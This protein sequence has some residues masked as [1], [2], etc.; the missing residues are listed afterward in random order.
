[1]TERINFLE[2]SGQALTYKKMLIYAAAWVLV[3]VTVFVI[4]LG[5]K[6]TVNS[7]VDN[8]KQKLVQLNARKENTM[9]LIEA[10]NIPVVKTEVKKLSEIFDHFPVWSQVLYNLA[11]T[12][13]SQVWL[14]SLSSSYGSGG[15]SLRRLE[16]DGSGQSASTIANF[17]TSLNN[18]PL[19]QNFIL[20]KS[21]RA[22]VAKGSTGYSFLIIGEVEFKGKEWN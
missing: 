14:T 18:I 15:A 22:D 21:T 8:A 19:F 2:K 1:M 17:V 16:I 11:K 10:S 3:C 20:N 4:E 13:P 6:W 5:Y 7:I 9:A 12:I